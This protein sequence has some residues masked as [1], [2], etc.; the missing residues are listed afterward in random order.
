MAAKKPSKKPTRPMPATIGPSMPES[1]TVRIRRIENGYIVTTE[2]VTKKGYES[3]DTYMAE[4][5]KL[6][7]PDK[8]KK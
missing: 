8:G 4:A 6:N 3:R 5:P 7:L 1:E 2:R